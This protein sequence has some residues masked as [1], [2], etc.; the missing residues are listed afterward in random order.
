MRSVHRKKSREPMGRP[1]ERTGDALEY[2]WGDQRIG[3]QNRHWWG[4][5]IHGEAAASL[6]SAC[7]VR[8]IYV[9]Q[10]ATGLVDRPSQRHRCEFEIGEQARVIVGWQGREKMILFRGMR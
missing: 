2:H 8:E 7:S 9:T 4:R 6:S 5:G 3:R 1:R 10:M